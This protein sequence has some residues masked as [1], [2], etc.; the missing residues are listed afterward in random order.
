MCL[1]KCVPF[2][3][4]TLCVR[5]V[6]VCVNVSF[7]FLYSMCALCMCLCKCVP[8]GFCTLCVRYAC[9]CVNVFHSVFVLYVCV[10]QVFM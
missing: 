5:Y 8:F 9:V 1:C 10:M 4:C 6:C 2:G 3:F 7:R